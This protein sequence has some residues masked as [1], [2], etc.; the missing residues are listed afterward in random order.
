MKKSSVLICT[1]TGQERDGW[2]HPKLGAFLTQCALAAARGERQIQTLR[3][4]G[5][6]PHDF[7][8]NVGA[9]SFL[10]KS[11]LDWLCML[12][13]D[14]VPCDGLLKIIDWAAPDADVVVP[15]FYC[16]TGNSKPDQV[17]LEL[18]WKLLPGTSIGSGWTEIEGAASHCMFIRRRVFEKLAKPYFNFVYRDDGTV[19]EG[20]DLT[21]CAKARAA[22]FKIFGYEG[23]E[24]DHVKSF[25]LS[26][27]ARIAGL[28][29]PAQPGK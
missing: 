4:E 10:E 28:A 27:L 3:L 6:R 25:S 19:L 7:A 29:K 2:L 15:K 20:E 16:L 17:K 11:Q 18:G 26:L 9:N 14:S 21:F 8:R 1:L 5:Y 13:N 24:V 22:G 12:D 23:A